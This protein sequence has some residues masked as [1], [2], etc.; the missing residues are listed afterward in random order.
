MPVLWPP[1]EKRE[2][3]KKTLMRGKMEGRRRRGRQR[4]RWLDRTMDSKDMTL[5]KL[6]ER[7]K[8]REAWCAA[9]HG[10]SKSQRRLSDGT[11][12]TLGR[13]AEA[14]RAVDG[15]GTLWGQ[16]VRDGEDNQ[17][18]R[19]G[20][21]P[22]RMVCFCSKKPTIIAVANTRIAMTPPRVA[23]FQHPLFAMMTL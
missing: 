22:G 7:V 17:I 14:N 15:D 3:L 9:V 5:T 16:R 23:H 21:L 12:A 19:L 13:R 2:S 1:D 10:V 18:A 6:W 20:L 4:M 8:A 11:A